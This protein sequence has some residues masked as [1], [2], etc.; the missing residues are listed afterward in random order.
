MSTP[1]SLQQKLDASGEWATELAELQ[2][3]RNQALNMGGPEALAKFK[4]SGRLNA[5]ERLSLIH[6]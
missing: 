2:L 4:A 5:R 1:T 3:R 6:I